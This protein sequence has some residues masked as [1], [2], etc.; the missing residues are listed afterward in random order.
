MFGINIA[1]LFVKVGAD[2]SDLDAK[3]K[4]ID[5]SLKPL[6][7]VAKKFTSVGKD[8]TMGVTLPILA[9]AG[10]TIL[11]AKGYDECMDSIR[12]QTGLT[13]QALDDFGTRLKAAY[14]VDRQSM[15]QTAEAMGLLYQ[16][17]G[18][19]GQALEDLTVKEGLLSSMLKTDFNGTVDV[20]TQLFKAWGMTTDE[21]SKYLDT[22]LNM[23]QQTGASAADLA[24]AVGQNAL[25][26]QSMGYTVEQAT[27]MV[28]NL[29]ASGMSAEDVISGMSQATRKLTTEQAAATQALADGKINQDEYNLIMGETA[30]TYLA[31]YIEK[32]K[33]A[34]SETE[35][36]TLAF[37]AFGPKGVNFA[38]I[39]RDDKL[40][41]EELNAMLAGGSDSINKAAADTESA[42]DK[43]DKMKKKLEVDLIPIG[44]KLMETFVKLEPVIT[45]IINFVGGLIEAFSKLDPAAQTIII[46]ILGLA[47]A[48][49]PVLM[50]LGTMA[51]AVISINLLLPT[52]NTLLLG[53]AGAT[54][55]LT[56]A[57]SALLV[58][59]GLL[60]AALVA[61]KLIWDAFDV[62]SI[63]GIGGGTTSPLINLGGEH[64]YT[65]AATTLSEDTMQTDEE[66]RVSYLKFLNSKGVK[67]HLDKSNNPVIDYMPSGVKLASG[68]IVT[69]PTQALVGESGPE[70]VIPLGPSSMFSG[71][72]TIP[73][74]IQ[75][76]DR[77][78]MRVVKV[79]GPE[80]IRSLSAKTGWNG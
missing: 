57:V 69:R 11:A 38:K 54:G 42:T 18:L 74:T 55:T 2:L 40:S 3:M 19:T 8:L 17:T 14:V 15:D 53:S 63:F 9:I 29:M 22:L 33:D 75:M 12:A 25:M 5:K 21:D 51:H 66:N 43:F 64:E 46:L 30:Q 67:Y 60:L 71:S 41:I 16:R 61:I 58:P 13:G 80:L 49:G 65:G 6:D 73:I 76:G 31:K 68:G 23:C 34:T 50:L 44:E 59:L 20:T 78:I 77:E 79:I 4:S 52:L 32:I 72:I 37:E 56:V 70:A 36:N 7:N 62:G 45:G 35:A 47:A 39:I 27:A 28:A 48:L 24:A 10:A 1:S 26:F